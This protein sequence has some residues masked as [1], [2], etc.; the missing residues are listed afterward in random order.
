ML[1]K[2]VPSSGEHWDRFRRLYSGVV[3]DALV[4]ELG[5]PNSALPHD[6]LPL[7]ANMKVIGPAFTWKGKPV[8]EKEEVPPFEEATR[9]WFRRI[10]AMN[11]VPGCVLVIDPGGEN[12]SAHWGELSSHA[13][14]HLGC[15]GAVIDG[16]VRDADLIESAGFALFARYRTMVDGYGLFLIT[17]HQVPVSIG[18]VE[19]RPWDLVFGDSD[20]VIIVPRDAAETV[21]AKAEEIFLEE[22]AVREGLI[23]GTSVSELLERFT[24]A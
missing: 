1:E 22:S 2:N 21:F 17:D 15:Q 7:H 24:R 16:G 14:K 4:T 19:I 8:T 12:V 20:G 6:L 11:E 18:G 10:A 13:A 5:Y 23:A 9:D 3:Y